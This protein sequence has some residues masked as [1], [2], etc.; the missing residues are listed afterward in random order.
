[1]LIKNVVFLIK[2]KHF[3]KIKIIICITKLKNEIDVIPPSYSS[4]TILIY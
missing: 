4:R 2:S 1:M 3:E